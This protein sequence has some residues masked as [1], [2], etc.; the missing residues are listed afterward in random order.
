MEIV[1]EDITVS[2]GRG[3]SKFKALDA[4]NLRVEANSVYGLVGPSGCGK[5]SI[6][7]CCLGL[8]KP[9]S[10]TVSLNGQSPSDPGLGVPGENVGYMPQELSLHPYFTP[11][12]VLKY[13]GLVFKVPDLS[14]RIDEVLELL[15]L[16]K[17][18]IEH[19]QNDRLSGGQQRRVSLGCA[20]IHR[21]K[22]VIL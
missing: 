5:T 14:E 15:D 19:R 12:E 22:L 20:L 21:P 9:Q 10:G 4:V 17:N 8:V 6:L 13:Y 16:R 11:R 2:Y 7:S 3:K 1:L 18:G